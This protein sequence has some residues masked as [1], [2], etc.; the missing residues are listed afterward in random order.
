MNTLSLTYSFKKFQF[1]SIHNLKGV[2]S[3]DI[4]TFIAF[5][6]RI[7]NKSYSERFK[8]YDVKRMA[9]F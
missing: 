8:F 9:R 5:R 6:F 1:I 3:E 2:N 7:P 4:M